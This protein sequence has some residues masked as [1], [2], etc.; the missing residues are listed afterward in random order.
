M[1]GDPGRLRQVLTNLIGNAVK[2]T[3]HGQVSLEMT[4]GSSTPPRMVQFR[5][6]DTGIGVAADAQAAI[7]ESFSQADSST[8]RRYGGTGLGLAISRQLVELMGGTLT[9]QSELGNGSTFSFTLP[10]ECGT[11]SAPPSRRDDLDGL[12]ALIVDDNA[13]NRTIL[14]RFLDEW[15]MQ[16]RSAEDAASGLVLLREAAASDEPF[17]IAVID[18]HMPLMDG[19]QMAR[20]MRADAAL[21]SVRSVLLTSSGQRGEAGLAEAAGMEGYLTKPVRQSHLYGCLTTVMGIQD[22]GEERRIVTRHGLAERTTPR[23]RVLVAEDNAVNRKVAIGMLER[24]GYQVDVVGDGAEAVHATAATSYAAVLMDCQMP[25]LD[26]YEATMRIRQR[27]G[28]QKHTPIIALTAS[29]MKADQQRCV[30]AGMDDHLTKPVRYEDLAASLGRWAVQPQG[31][32][33]AHAQLPEPE[34][35]I[36]VGRDPD[37]VAR[38]AELGS[39]LGQELVTELEEIFTAEAPTRVAGMRAALAQRDRPG[40]STAAHALRGTSA[41]LGARHLSSLCAALE[42]AGEDSDASRLLDSIEAELDRVY[43]AFGPEAAGTP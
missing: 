1:R 38:M 6:V 17:D 2:F 12:R 22:S 24:L 14:T 25:Q 8:T 11:Q 15:G 28:G 36:P 37:V 19:L 16:T 3:E 40:V 5:I 31:S 33:P 35:S 26:G 39:A 34:P 9:V 13:T 18:L 32:P 43:L 21:A 42:D 27:E 41:N 4:T 7:F 23:G 10:L 30:E 20:A 29:A